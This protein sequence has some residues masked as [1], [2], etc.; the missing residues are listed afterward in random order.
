MAMDQP[1][2]DGDPQTPAIL[3]MVP[4]SHDNRLHDGAASAIEAS[5]KYSGNN[6]IPHLSTPRRRRQRR[7]TPATGLQQQQHTNDMSA[8]R[9]ILGGVAVAVLVMAV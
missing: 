7:S 4:L 9:K 3:T 2:S 1:D 6:V 8:M 5:G